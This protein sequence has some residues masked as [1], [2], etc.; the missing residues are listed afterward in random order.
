MMLFDLGNCFSCLS[1]RHTQLNHTRGVLKQARLN[2]DHVF[3]FQLGPVHQ[4]A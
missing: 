3:V 4:P 1:V 2:L